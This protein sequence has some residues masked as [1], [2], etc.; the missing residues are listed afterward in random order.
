MSIE[1]GNL[2]LDPWG[3]GNATPGEDRIGHAVRMRLTI[4]EQTPFVK[5]HS[6]EKLGSQHEACLLPVQAWG[7]GGGTAPGA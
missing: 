5:F 3:R 1:R 7:G 4:P 2:G 6:Y